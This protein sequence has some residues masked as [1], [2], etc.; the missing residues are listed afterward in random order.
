MRQP[1]SRNHSLSVSSGSLIPSHRVTRRKSVSINNV[2]A[3]AAAVKEAGDNG[4]AM[5]MAPSTRRKS[6]S[7][8]APKFGS[9]SNYP[10]PPS[11]L[12]NNKNSMATGLKS[13]SGESAIDDA[14]HEDGV[15]DEEHSS[16][17]ARTRRASEGQHM[18]KG[19]GKKSAPGDIR[20]EKCGKGYK[21]SSCL[22]K[23]LF[24]PISLLPISSR[25]WTTLRR[26]AAP[27]ETID[28]D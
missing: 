9:L 21:H 22:T 4:F 6:S 26:P 20:C 1:Y 28:R 15:D 8:S 10:S 2:A 18:V 12:P 24:V 25:R 14:H 17:N 16:A 27:P 3:M 13:E 5:P 23:H 11:S 7:K 19:K